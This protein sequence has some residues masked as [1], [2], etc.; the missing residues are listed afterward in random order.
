M[1]R[2]LLPFYGARGR[3][4]PVARQPRA[5]RNAMVKAVLLAETE[6]PIAAK[7]QLYLKVK[8]LK[9]HFL[10]RRRRYRPSIAT[11][12]SYSSDYRK[13]KSAYHIFLHQGFNKSF[14]VMRIIYP[15]L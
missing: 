9:R 6:R 10:Q 2:A 13:Q 5:V 14:I 3:A 12:Q 4:A 1:R 8:S 11:D 7:I 15:S